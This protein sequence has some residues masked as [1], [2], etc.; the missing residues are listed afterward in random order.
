MRQISYLVF[1]VFTLFSCNNNKGENKALNNIVEIIF[2]KPDSALMLLDSMKISSYNLFD[3][4]RFFLYRT[5]AKD[6]SKKDIY[7]DKEMI[8]VY[9]FFYDKGSR[10]LTGLAAL[11][12]GRVL[13]QNEDFD[14]AITYYK[15]AEDIAKNS[16]NKEQQGYITFWIGMLMLD[17]YMIED[18]KTKLNEANLYFIQTNNHEYEIKLQ[19]NIG[20]NYLLTGNI[21]SSLFYFNKALDLALLYGDVKEQAQI[22]QNI[23][24]ALDEKK[25]YKNAIKTL[26]N[27]IRID[28]SAHKSG[29]VFINLAQ[30]YLNL[31]QLDSAKYYTD[32]CFEWAIRNKTSNP[33]LSSIVYNLKSQIAE[34]ANNNKEALEYQKEYTKNF[35][36]FLTENKNSAI[37]EAEMKYKFES[38]QKENISLTL[39][40]IRIERALILVLL[41]LAIITI[42]YYMLIL[43]KNKQL[44]KANEE[45][46]NMT[47]QLNDYHITKEDYKDNLLQNFNLLKRAASLEYFVQDT[48][49]K[50]GK[51]LIKRFN[52][53]AYGQDTIDWDILYKII[54]SIHNGIFDKLKEKYPDM[55]EA[56][57]KI[58]CLIYSR[59]NSNE[60]SVI[61]QLSVNTVHMKTTNIR[62]YL[63]V[64]KYGN[65]IDFLDK[66]LI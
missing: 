53:I 45:I 37:I 41:I 28:S 3:Q 18:A 64:E 62:K 66:T 63:G 57:Y 65:I 39:E 1:I 15:I 43:R 49:N 55:E 50:Q 13:H 44:N 46:L 11:Y 59:F 14:K 4:N 23:G 7:M 51:V 8:N 21:D 42:F 40:H 27:A 30:S 10:E 5:Q 6:L 2:Q 25:D 58:C 54:N 38:M 24:V 32:Y 12:A 48:G 29:R 52:E 26:K 61:S 16:K 19:K 56:S 20:I 35:V 31:G 36:N 60:I 34:Y 47:D 22:T 17:Q 9:E 33:R